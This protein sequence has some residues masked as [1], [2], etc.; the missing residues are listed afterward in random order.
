MESRARVVDGGSEDTRSTLPRRARQTSAVF[1]RVA[2]RLQ[3]LALALQV[4]NGQR[5]RLQPERIESQV[6]RRAF[7][8]GANALRR[9]TFA[10]AVQQHRDAQQDG[11]P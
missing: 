3:E 10:A 11:E 7:G 6:Q 2:D 8:P 1:E 4:R 9:V 5:I